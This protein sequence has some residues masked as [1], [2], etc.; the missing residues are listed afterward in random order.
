M[1]GALCNAGNPASREDGYLR[2]RHWQVTIG[3]RRQYSHRHFIGTKEQFDRQEQETEVVNRIHL[4]DVSVT[5]QVKPRWSLNFS[6]PVMIASRTV[7]GKIFQLRGI[8]NAPDQISHTRGI[9]DVSFSARTW[10]FRPPA[11]SRQNIAFGFGIKLPTGEPGATDIINTVNGPV[12]RVADQSIQLGDGGLGVVFSTEAFKVV[13]KATFF[14]SGVYLVNPRNTN[15]VQTARSRPSEAIMSVADQYLAQIG[16]AYPFPQ[17][18]GLAVIFG[19]RLEGVPVR[20]L[21]GK[22][23]GFRR[24]GYALSLEP[25]L[26]Y[27]HGKHTWS[28]N[29]P[30]AVQ[31]NRRRSVPDILDGRHG[32]AAFADYL[33][34]FSVTRSF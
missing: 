33:I 6:V 14:L 7:P 16:V 19:G 21:F 17:V 24:P 18:R 28:V 30:V 10:L 22:S 11:E 1:I 3:Y 15:G 31:R 20:D 34:L 26:V 23:E 25:E 8:P 5:Y 4:M 27:T 2:P 9:G 12:R 13:R 29:V 32:D